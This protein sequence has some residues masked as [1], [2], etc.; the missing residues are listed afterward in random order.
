MAEG[1]GESFEE[2]GRE[3]AMEG[4]GATQL[5]PEADEELVQR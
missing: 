1:G 5:T 4:I 3:L 2:F